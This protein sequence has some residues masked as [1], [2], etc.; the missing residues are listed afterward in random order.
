M[1]ATCVNDERTESDSANNTV[2]EIRREEH[3]STH[4]HTHTHAHKH[5]SMDDTHTAT[6]AQTYRVSLNDIPAAVW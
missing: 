5:T 4:T 6:Y 1:I 2:D 3:A